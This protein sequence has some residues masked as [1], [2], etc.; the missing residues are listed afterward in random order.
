MTLIRQGEEQIRQQAARLQVLSDASRAFSAVGPNYQTV[1]DEITTTISR[2]LGDVCTLRLLDPDTKRFGDAAIYDDT[3]EQHAIMR[4]IMRNVPVDTAMLRTSKQVMNS[5]QPLLL[6]PFDNDRLRAVLPD[7][8]HTLVDKLHIH[9]AIIAPLRTQGVSFGVMY[10]S[11]HRPERP[12][13]DINDLSLVQD[14]ADRAALAISNAQLYGALQQ[15]HAALE[16]RVTERTAELRAALER[17]RALYAITNDAIGSDDLDDALQRTIERVAATL[18]ADRIVMATFDLAGQCIERQIAGGPNRHTIQQLATFEHYFNGLAGWAMRELRPAISAKGRPDQRENAEIQQ[19]RQRS[20]T[21]S[22]I[23]AP[24]I[25]MDEAFGVL[26]AINSLDDPDFT[27][28]D[29]DLM[30]AVAS[31]VS[32]VYA[33]NRLTARLQHT[34]IA[35]ANEIAERT[36]LARWQQQQA[37]QAIGLAALSQ[38]MAEIS[39]DLQALFNTITQRIAWLMKD[40]C[41]LSLLSEDRLWMQPVAIAGPRSEEVALLKNIVHAAPDRADTG[42]SATI[43]ISGQALLLANV[44]VAYVR[45]QVG[46]RYVEFLEGLSEIHLLIVPLRARGRV[47]GSICLTRLASHPPYSRADE[48][49]LQDLGDRAGLAIENARLFAEA[50][51]ARAEAER[52]N[53]AKSAFLASISHELRT[54]LNAIVGFTGTLLMRLPGPLTADQ[55]RQLTTIQRSSRHLLALINDLLDLGRIESGRAEICLAPVSCRELLAEVVASLRPLADAKHIGLYTRMPDAAV[56]IQSDA[57][58]LRQILINLVNNAVKFTDNGEVWVVLERHAQ[59]IHIAI[60][61]TGIGIR[62]EDQAR[63][64]QEFGRADTAEVRAREGTGL[65]LRISRKLADVLGGTI[66]LESEFGKGSTF[67]LILPIEHTPIAEE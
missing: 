46:A 3:P 57:R 38:A 17:V 63:L 35:L 48:R 56:H 45:S 31:Q 42:W 22:M 66:E 28:E 55:E 27:A 12:M 33:R 47:L 21:G 2:A 19:L 29:V 65:G 61:D 14:L 64:F 18:R 5:A 30:V 11:R 16:A 25:S 49:F 53:R 54:P 44:P 58:A 4:D 13:F 51:L 6:A 20:Q 62:P 37:E 15:S 10:V 1:L 36:E 34:N 67:T 23:V 26:M 50:E 9:S 52:A 60:T 8:Y 7:R 39:L 40:L 32:I 41:V 59:Q 24:L 43:A